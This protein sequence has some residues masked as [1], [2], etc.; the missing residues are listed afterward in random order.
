MDSAHHSHFPY[1]LG[2]MYDE[3][4]NKERKKRKEMNKLEVFVFDFLNVWSKFHNRIERD[5]VCKLFELLCFDLIEVM[6]YLIYRA[7]FEP[8]HSYLRSATVHCTS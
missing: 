4:R 8:A 2:V 5:V 7:N 3:E 6:L 1:T